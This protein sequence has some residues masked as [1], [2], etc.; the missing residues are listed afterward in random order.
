MRKARAG[1]EPSSIS[2][3]ETKVPADARE[4][5]RDTRPARVDA[6][7]S[8]LKLAPAVIPGLTLLGW[9]ASLR[10][11]DIRNTTDLGL[12]S[13]LPVGPFVAFAVL[14]VSFIWCLR[15]AR[16][17]TLVLGAHVG[18]LIVMLFGLATVIEDLPRSD[19]AWRH[20]G[21]AEEIARNG[22]VDPLIDAYFN[23]PGFFVAVASLT[24]A[25]GLSNALP[26]IA[27]TP[28][29]LN[30]AYL[31]PLLVI[32]RTATRD[33][34][35]VWLAVWVFYLA[36]WVGQDYF[37]PQGFMYFLHLTILAVV[38]RWFA[39][40]DPGQ[41]KERLLGHIARFRR[42]TGERGS[43]KTPQD[44]RVVELRAPNLFVPLMALVILVFLAI[45]PSHQLTPFMGAA[46]VGVLV[47]LGVSWARRLPVL[48]VIFATCWTIF[49]AT[50]YLK[51]HLETI[52]A[53]V[54]EVGENVDRSVGQR[55]GGSAEHVFVVQLRLALTGAVWLIAVAGAI[56]ARRAGRLHGSFVALA[57]APFFFLAVQPYGGEMLLRVYLF[58]LPFAAFLFALLLY[59]R[60]GSGRSSLHA[61]V[62]ATMVMIMM[63]S[64][65]IAR[66]GN[67]R[68]DYFTVEEHAAVERLYSEARP[69]SVLVAGVA[70]LPWRHRDYDRYDYTIL[71]R[72]DFWTRMVEDGDPSPAALAAST[73]DVLR[74]R[75]SPAY[76]IIT[77][78][79]KAEIDLF[80]IGPRGS[81][82]LLEDGATM[83]SDFTVVYRNRDATIFTL[84]SQAGEM[85]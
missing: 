15:Q 13:V 21:V 83:S 20:V 73:A 24:E 41:V 46:M 80:G 85:P 39:T 30:V 16:E 45:V 66:Y 52:L 1:V 81:L 63:V 57:L 49:F 70:N 5:S 58:S 36:N 22:A 59:P 7:R 78:S 37:S 23:W 55:I 9:A 48:M 84:A 60:L 43:T 75:E 53:A 64:F 4:A 34:R 74:S 17:M 38:L 65:V 32:F 25:A 40:S 14:V 42:T 77:R 44:E 10:S 26:L 68:A 8:L 61:G 2:G 50:A 51:G 56:R 82:A 79:Q 67:E 3:L 62:L 47:V 33:W 72:E 76:L 29:A 31:G 27:W 12:I 35:V 71:S 11:V 54:G 6:R 19:V 28:V 18:A 69:G